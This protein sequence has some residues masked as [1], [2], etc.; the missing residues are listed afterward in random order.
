MLVVLGLA[1]L[2]S[3]PQESSISRAS[4]A[5]GRV[6]EDGR[7]WLVLCGT[8]ALLIAASLTSSPGKRRLAINL[9]GLVAIAELGS[10]GFSLLQVAPVEQFVGHDPISNALGR[11]RE[12]SRAFGPPRIKARDAFY[13][14]LPA[15]LHG[16][17]KTNI[18]DAFQLDHAA[19]LYE[20]FYG[21]VSRPRRVPPEE[22]MDEAVAH[23]DR[24]VR[25]AVFDR[26]SVSFLVSDRF[27]SDPPWP[28]A[29][30]G[31]WNGSQFV[32]QRNPTAVARAYVVPRATVLKGGA[33]EALASFPD[34]DPRESV[35]LDHDPIAAIATS[36][37]QPF[38]AAQWASSDPDHPVLRVTTEAPGLLV[39]SDTWMPGWTARVDGTSAPI[40]RGNYAQRVIPLLRAGPHTIELDYWP[41]GFTQG[42]VITMVAA[43][44]WAI[45]CA[46]MMVGFRDARARQMLLVW[47]TDIWTRPGRFPE[48]CKNQTGRRKYKGLDHSRSRDRAGHRNESSSYVD[49]G[50]LQ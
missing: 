35:L 36:A 21:V 16:I 33:A 10:A 25:Q 50:S 14:D 7:L 44:T 39:M 37:R 22:P 17:E 46:S 26:M 5:A 47:M 30:T 42:G 23:F 6:I 31:D 41:P 18:N 2:A 4:Q 49:R 13:G 34:S 15:L 12:S 48:S 8:T 38:T 9:L 24:Q 45:G 40:Y 11:L 43:L 32:I 20:T 29:A 19:A 3:A 28:V 27:E 1:W